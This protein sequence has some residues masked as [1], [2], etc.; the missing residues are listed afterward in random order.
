MVTVP[1]IQ[2]YIIFAYCI[3]VFKSETDRMSIS[4]NEAIV[5]YVS[6]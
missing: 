2:C 6:Y 1:I 4:V 3:N 5:D